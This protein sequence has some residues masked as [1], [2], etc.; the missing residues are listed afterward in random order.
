VSLPMRRPDTGTFRQVH[1]PSRATGMLLLHSM[2]GRH[3]PLESIW[4][5]AAQLNVSL[6][7][8]L[9]DL[10][11]IRRKSPPYAAALEARQ[12]PFEVLPIEIP[13][14]GVPSDR[15][16][17]WESACEVGARVRR[18]E[19]VLIHCGAGIGRT[20]MF[21]TAV[22]IALGVSLESA[23]EAVREAGAGAETSAQR[24]VVAWCA[25]LELGG[26]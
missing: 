2:P 23:Q 18:G 25:A 6:I 16:A 15:Q 12:V 14:W 22:L 19:V 8:R 3:E 11:E 26:V 5:E 1:V 10:A 17:F 21:A 24:E 7:V 9:A 4:T 20:G 13:D